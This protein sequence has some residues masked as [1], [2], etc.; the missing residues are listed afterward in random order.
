MRIIIHATHHCQ[1]VLRP[2]LA[3]F[4][5]TQIQRAVD[6]IEQVL[7]TIKIS[8]PQAVYACSIFEDG[9]PGPTI[10]PA[11]CPFDANVA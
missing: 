5:G 9:F 6:A 2:V 4:A 8:H 7:I 1:K 10:V 11:C 3:K